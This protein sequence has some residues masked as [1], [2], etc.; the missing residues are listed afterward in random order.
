M[1]TIKWKIAIGKNDKIITLEELT[2]L[3]NNNLEDQLVIIG[4]LEHLK[5]KHLDKIKT[6]YEKT[7]R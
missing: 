4:I 5:Q 6:F 1:K 7:V 3:S 2:E